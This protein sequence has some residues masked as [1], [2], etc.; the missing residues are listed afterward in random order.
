MRLALACVVLLVV[1]V[2]PSAAQEVETQ[3]TTNAWNHKHPAWCG[4]NIVFQ[5]D[6]Y[7]TWDIWGADQDNA[8]TEWPQATNPTS[9]EQRPT[10]SGDC[11]YVYFQMKSETPPSADNGIY[12]VASASP[13][14]PVPLTTGAAD[15]RAPDWGPNGIAYHSDRLDGTTDDI[16]RMSLSGQSSGW[17]YLTTNTAYDQWPDWSPDATLVAF[18]SDRGGNGSS[19]IWIVS[20]ATEADSVRQVTNDLSDEIDPAWSPNGRWIAFSRQ[21]QG[22]FAV[23]VTTGDEVQITNGVTDGEPCWSPDGHTLAFSREGANWQIWKTTNVPTSALIESTTWGRI[24]AIY[25]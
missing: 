21:F 22:I 14:T 25:R 23:D 9:I 11:I 13:Q 17:E 4:R 12:Q 10:W 8:S 24:K 20:S 15:E 16:M 2:A 19:D 7:G 6:R 3:L 5:S 18:S 1:T